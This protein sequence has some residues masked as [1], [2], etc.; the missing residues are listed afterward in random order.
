MAIR[1]STS[2]I[3]AGFLVSLF[4]LFSY[5][6]FFVR[7]PVTRDLPWANLLLFA[8]SVTLVA[9]GL[10]RAL[11][12]PKRRTRLLAFMG[13]VL[14]ASAF[15]MF[16]IVVFVAGRQLPPSAGAPR[17]GQKAPEF[18]LSDTTGKTVSLSELLATPIHGQ[19]PRGV[20][21]VFYRGYW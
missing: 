16:V 7:W 21:L 19:A 17:V 13:A 18:A 6:F 11:A 4:A 14:S 1:R 8:A 12:E 15:A 3:W 9:T 2:L 5:P 20:L 10:R